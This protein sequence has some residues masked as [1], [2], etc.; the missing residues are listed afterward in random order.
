MFKKDNVQ[1]NVN[2][3][4]ITVQRGMAT[5]EHISGP[6]FIRNVSIDPRVLIRTGRN[7]IAY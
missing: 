1:P 2:P 3:K 4:P 7:D 6:V 5:G